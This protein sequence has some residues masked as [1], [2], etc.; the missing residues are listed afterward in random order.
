M[1]HFVIV[2]MGHHIIDSLN[3]QIQPG[4]IV[5][6]VGRSGSGKSTLTRLVQRL[7]APERGRVLIDGNDLSL[8]DPA[9]LR[10]QIGVVLQDNVLLNRSIRDNIALC[11]PG[12]ALREG[13]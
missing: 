1:W 9:W 7:Y 10:R 8:A 5:G 4:E 12:M 2:W 3:L 11:E 13:H 6:I